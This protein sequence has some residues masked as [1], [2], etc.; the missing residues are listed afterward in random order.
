MNPAPIDVIPPSQKIS[1]GIPHVIDISM[2]SIMQPSKSWAAKRIGMRKQSILLFKFRHLTRHLCSGDLR[3][4]MRKN[5]IYIES[6][7]PTLVVG[8]LHY[9]TQV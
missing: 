8:F 7:T 3:L 9:I 6:Y 4:V 5:F 2:A 1:K